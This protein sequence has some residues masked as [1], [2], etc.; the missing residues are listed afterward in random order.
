MKPAKRKPGRP[1]TLTLEKVEA[2]GEEEGETMTPERIRI[3]LAER[4]GFD[5]IG[6]DGL[7]GMRNGFIRDVPNY[8]EDL[9][10]THEMEKTLSEEEY[11]AYLDLLVTMIAGNAMNPRH[12]DYPK[13]VSATA[14]QRCDAFLRVKGVK[15]DTNHAT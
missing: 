5:H 10:A 12:R 2:V 8:P 4:M 3:K 11:H 9:N 1:R 14:Q 6:N 13:I 7:V 15:I